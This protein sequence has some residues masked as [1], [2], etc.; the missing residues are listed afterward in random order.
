MV[1]NFVSNGK[2]G[3]LVDG[4]FPFAEVVT[5]VSQRLS[6]YPIYPRPEHIDDVGNDFFGDGCVRYCVIDIVSDY[7]KVNLYSMYTIVT[8]ARRTLEVYVFHGREMFWVLSFV[9][10]V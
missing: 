6:W 1:D 4:S 9:V 5:R 8:F 2:Q 3:L 7:S 10:Y